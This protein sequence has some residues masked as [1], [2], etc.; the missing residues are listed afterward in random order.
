MGNNHLSNSFTFRLACIHNYPFKIRKREFSIPIC[1]PSVSLSFSRTFYSLSFPFLKLLS[2]FKSLPQTLFRAAL[3][4]GR[5]RASVSLHF[6]RI[7]SSRAA[8]RDASRCVAVTQRVVDR[9]SRVGHV[10]W[11]VYA[12][13]GRRR[14]AAGKGASAA[15][16]SR[17][18]FRSHASRR[19][20]SRRR[21][22]V[23]RE[24][25]VHAHAHVLTR[26]RARMFQSRTVRPDTKLCR[27]A[28]R[29]PRV[30]RRDTRVRIGSARRSRAQIY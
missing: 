5:D 15:L 27:I 16:C 22:A 6:L 14:D 28:C 9:I 17:W 12:S 30:T 25:T 13:V 3:A 29:D 23:A 26:G 7:L 11:H 10:T 20:V 21:P 19:F 1:Y 2:P 18:E 24:T 8:R 4:A